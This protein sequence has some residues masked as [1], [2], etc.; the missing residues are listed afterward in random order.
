MMVV[1]EADRKNSLCGL[2]GL[3]DLVVIVFIARNE[4]NDPRW[5]EQENHNISSN[6]IRL[7]REACH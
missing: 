3:P 1:V 5:E 2:E 7:S 4:T 6:R